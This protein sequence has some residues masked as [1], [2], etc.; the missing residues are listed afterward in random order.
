[1]GL[2]SKRQNTTTLTVDSGATTVVPDI[3]A[4]RTVGPKPVLSGSS[5]SDP[6]TFDVLSNTTADW[7][8]RQTLLGYANRV[9]CEQ[10]DAAGWEFRRAT[11][12]SGDSSRRLD[13]DDTTLQVVAMRGYCTSHVQWDNIRRQYRDIRHEDFDRLGDARFTAVDHTGSPVCVF[14]VGMLVIRV[15]MTGTLAQRQYTRV[16][17]LDVSQVLDWSALAEWTQRTAGVL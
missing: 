8:R 4:G 3:L 5:A 1:M 11:G 6:G 13:E 7:G 10:A 17:A 9:R 16:Y 14:R 2:F 15:R 12:V